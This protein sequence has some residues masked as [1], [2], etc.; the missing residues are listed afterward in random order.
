MKE[1]MLYLISGVF[2]GAFLMMGMLIVSEPIE[3][4]KTLNEAY[5]GRVLQDTV[6]D[7]V[8]SKAIWNVK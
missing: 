3:G 7:F 5:K 2:L 1:P 6:K 4:V 8:P